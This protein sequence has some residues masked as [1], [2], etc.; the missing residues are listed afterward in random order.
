MVETKRAS[1]KCGTQFEYKASDLFMKPLSYAT[2]I[3]GEKYP[4]DCAA[5]V[6]CPKCNT[7]IPTYDRLDII[8]EFMD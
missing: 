5:A 4:K 6:R 2:D 1:C 7:E 8:G 3:T